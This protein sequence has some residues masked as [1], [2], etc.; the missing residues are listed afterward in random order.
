MVVCK[1]SH[2]QITR[3]KCR[4]KQTHVSSQPEVWGYHGTRA[5]DMLRKRWRSVGRAWPRPLASVESWPCSHFPARLCSKLCITEGLCGFT[6]ALPFLPAG[7]TPRPWKKVLV[8][9]HMPHSKWST[10]PSHNTLGPF[11]DGFGVSFMLQV[12]PSL[13]LQKWISISLVH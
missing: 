4:W 7:L 1:M 12:P 6:W 5:W 3:G 9:R 10:G 11:A 8:L 2:V 13:P